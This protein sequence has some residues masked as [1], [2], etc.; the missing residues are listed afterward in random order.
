MDEARDETVEVEVTVLR[1]EGHGLA[2]PLEESGDHAGRGLFALRPQQQGVH[3]CRY[4]VGGV[5][6]RAASSNGTPCAVNRRITKLNTSS[7]SRSKC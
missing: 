5:C 7:E 3:V 1:T 6:P 4:S 2:R